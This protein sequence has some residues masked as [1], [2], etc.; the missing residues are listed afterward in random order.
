MDCQVDVKSDKALALRHRKIREFD[1]IIKALREQANE[2]SDKVGDLQIIIDKIDK[3]IKTNAEMHKQW[4]EYFRQSIV[5]DPKEMEHL[6]DY[7]NAIKEDMKI[8]NEI[9]EFLLRHVK[10]NK[11]IK[12]MSYA[13]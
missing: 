1:K 5:K 8:G 12:T 7:L 10:M 6:E 11:K 2:L 13:T 4:M 3:F 9:K